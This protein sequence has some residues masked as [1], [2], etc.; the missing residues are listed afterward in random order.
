MKLCLSAIE[1]LLLTAHAKE[2][3]ETPFEGKPVRLSSRALPT[4]LLT[5]PPHFT[6]YSPLVYAF[7]AYEPAPPVYEP[8]DPNEVVCEPE[9]EPFYAPTAAAIFKLLLPLTASPRHIVAGIREASRVGS[10]EAVR[11]GFERLEAIHP[12]ARDGGMPLHAKH[13]VPLVFA[14]HVTKSTCVQQMIDLF[15]EYAFLVSANRDDQYLH[16]NALHLAISYGQAA[17]VERVLA[18]GADV[19]HLAPSSRNALHALA[20]ACVEEDVALE[21]VDKLLQRPGATMVALNKPYG[22]HD[23]GPVAIAL[24]MG[25]PRVALR[26]AEKGGQL[27]EWEA[28]R[29]IKTYP[30]GHGHLAD[31]PYLTTLVDLNHNSILPHVA[32]AYNAHG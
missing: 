25:K 30:E 13:R 26:L 10:V 27:D 22:P 7:H 8:S 9:P 6:G 15:L 31:W 17:M 16:G 21:I 32:A 18:L 28:I 11:A 24:V 5:L 12:G 20:Q 2:L 1:L 14:T 19:A 23:L 29:I 3:V 4:A